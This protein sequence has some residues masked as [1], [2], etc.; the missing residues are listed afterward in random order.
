[1][2]HKEEPH[3][4]GNVA[5]VVPCFNENNTILKFIDEVDSILAEMEQHFE[6]I[7]VDDA[8]VDNTLELLMEHKVK[9][10]NVQLRVIQNRYNLGHQGAIYQGLCYA[11]QLDCERVIVMDGDGEDDPAGIPLL[12]KVD[13][14]DVINV[15][16]GKR[17]ESFL[18]RFFY[19]LYKLAFKFVTGKYI[20]F[21]NYSLISRRTLDAAVAKSFISYPAF[22]LKTKGKKKSITL[23]RRK[24]LDG[25]SKM[26]MNALVYHG[27]RSFS[28]FAEEF[29]LLLLK[30]AIALALLFLISIGVIFYIRIFTDKAIT[31]WASTMS[32]SFFNAALISFGFF[33]IGIVLLNIYHKNQK[34]ETS[35]FKI[36]K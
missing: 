25:K 19:W 13:S 23:N 17:S 21:G 6:L 32:A 36:I 20:D 28:E 2:S 34:M 16:R 30:M 4:M 5:I 24:R 35:G 3:I 22:L 31:G 8:S 18:F 12:L 14:A 11:Q 1:M 26:S 9:A 7:V 15:K 27:F 29:I 10:G 33:F